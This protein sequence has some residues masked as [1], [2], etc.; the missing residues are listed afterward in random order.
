M[1]AN[2]NPKF[3]IG[4]PVGTPGCLEAI[5][6]AGQTPAEF[7]DRHVRLDPGDLDKED[8]QANEDALV[9]GGRIFS[10]FNTKQNVKLWCITE[11]DRSSTCILLPADY[12]S[13]VVLSCKS[14][15][16]GNQHC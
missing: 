2:T 9:H 16:S 14:S 6:A 7:L 8:Q 4:K 13:K 10:A 5:A 11:A 3:Q 12:L 1:I 15:P